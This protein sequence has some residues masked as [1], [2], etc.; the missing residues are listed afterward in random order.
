MSSLQLTDET[1]SDFVS[2]VNP[3]ADVHCWSAPN[4]HDDSMRTRLAELI[5]QFSHIAFAEFEIDLPRHMHI[6]VEL[7]VQ[8]QS[9]T[10]RR[11]NRKL[12]NC[13]GFIVRR[14]FIRLRLSAAVSLPTLGNGTRSGGHIDRRW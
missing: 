2:D 4:G 9:V 10:R 11:Q 3:Y 14:S 5:P 13:V 6:C 7:N 1:F 12:R 8:W